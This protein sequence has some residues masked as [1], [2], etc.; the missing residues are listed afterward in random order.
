MITEVKAVQSE[1]AQLSIEVTELEIATD[2][3]PVHSANAYAS[4]EVTV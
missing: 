4:I 3:K 2:I 1:N